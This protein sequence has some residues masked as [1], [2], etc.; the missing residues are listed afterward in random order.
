M[1]KYFL[2]TISLIIFSIIVVVYFRISQNLLIKT[3]N[4]KE[5]KASEDDSERYDNVDTSD[6]LAH[7]K[8]DDFT[9][10]E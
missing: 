2:A 7:L 6:P 9:F 10:L 1:D 4:S 3:N 8:A 5:E